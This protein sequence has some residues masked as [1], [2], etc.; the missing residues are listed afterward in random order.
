MGEQTTLQVSSVEPGAGALD[1]FALATARLDEERPLRN[2]RLQQIAVDLSNGRIQSA[3]DQLNDHLAANPDDVD[4]IFLLAEALV[5]AGRRGEA[6][7][8]LERCI[9]LAPDFTAARFA[10]ARLLLR[11]NRF[12]AGLAEADRL[13]M[14]D[15]EN[16]LFLQLKA[17]ALLAMGE[18]EGSLAIWR[19]LAADNSTRAQ[20]WIKYGDALRATGFQEGAVAAYR[21]AISCASVRRF[22]LVEPCQSEGLSLQRCR[23]CRDAAGTKTSR[24]RGRR[25][26][27][28]PVC[29]GKGLRRSACPPSR[30]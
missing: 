24:S 12:D 9:E 29:A 19:Q 3:H 13:L 15:G 7:S 20:S 22:G 26:N 11:L 25:S 14:D 21:T 23:D 1:S 10:Y 5:R 6:A 17:N 8:R 16:P 18:N 28:L 2:R 27:P 4:A 30:L